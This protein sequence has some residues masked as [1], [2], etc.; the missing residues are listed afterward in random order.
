MSM[1]LMTLVVA[2]ILL[3][4]VTLGQ[5]P[6]G[7]TVDQEKSEISS[8]AGLLQTVGMAD[9]LQIAGDLRKS[10]ES[11][12]R[13]GDSISRV[14]SVA[15][16]AANTTSQNMADTSEGFDP[17]G[18]KT[19]FETIQQQNAIIQEQ[20]KLIQDLQ[21]KEIDRLEQRQE[22]DLKSKRESRR[23]KPAARRKSP[24]DALTE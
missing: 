3:T 20:S 1:K 4:S 2:Q 5:E 8:L 13:F 19:A 6:L 9:M 17:F 7:A 10:S 18:F 12:E 22:S 14:F 15:A 24:K 11:L 23:K 16:D 21:Q